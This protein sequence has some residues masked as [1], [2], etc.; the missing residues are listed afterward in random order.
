MN[1]KILPLKITAVIALSAT[2]LVACDDTRVRISADNGPRHHSGHGSYATHTPHN[3]RVSYDSAIGMYVVLGLLNTYW[4]GSNYYRY[5]NTGWQR[6]NDYRL[7]NNVGITYVPNNL[8]KRHSHPR[9][10]NKNRRLRL[11]H[12]NSH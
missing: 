3:H 6:S 11:R 2:L 10:H 5:N 7:W 9:R 12:L 8:H 4:N 1:K